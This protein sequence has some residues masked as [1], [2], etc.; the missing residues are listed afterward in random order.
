M[1]FHGLFKVL[2]SALEDQH[3]MDIDP[4]YRVAD[5]GE[6]ISYSPNAVTSPATLTSFVDFLGT[7]GDDLT[8]VGASAL[9]STLNPVF[10]LDGD[11]DD[12]SS[13]APPSAGGSDATHSVV[14]IQPP[15]RLGDDDELSPPT[16]LNE[17]FEMI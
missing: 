5:V 6:T 4:V 1:G 8:S 17:D 9:G 3:G 15:P 7:D 14:S 16:V 13:V 2:A 10:A 12:G 11:A